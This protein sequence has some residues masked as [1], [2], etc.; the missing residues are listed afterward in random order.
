MMNSKHLT[1]AVSAALLSAA[2][3]GAQPLGTQF[4][5][6][7]Q[8]AVIDLCTVE[9]SKDPVISA[10]EAGL[11]VE[12]SVDEGSMVDEDQQLGRVDDDVPKMQKKVT[13]FQMRQARNRAT[14]TVDEDYARAAHDVALKELESVETANQTTDRAF[15]MVEVQRARLEATRSEMAIKKSLND[16]K[17]S[18][19]D[20]WTRKAEYEAADLAVKRRV[21]LAPTQGEVV[22][23]FHQ[24]GEWVNPGEPILQLFQLDTL[25]V[26]G[27]L[28]IEK[29]DPRE[30][31]G[32]DVMVDVIVG[33]GR[34]TQAT[35]KIVW[36]SPQGLYRGRTDRER[37]RRVRAEITNEREG[38]YWKI[39][40]GDEASMTIHL[41]TAQDVQVGQRQE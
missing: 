18:E 31:L 8:S 34:K 38:G 32:C 22:K 12:L 27:D 11:L 19:D 21:I 13:F 29:Y 25:H 28:N 33:G 30:V 37:V 14:D 35:G 1:Q 16:R 10:S 24:Q 17:L 39:Y 4:P 26:E 15:P 36:I 2:A 3:A 6:S 7:T 40:P 9:P 23:L 41:G 5:A 20:Y